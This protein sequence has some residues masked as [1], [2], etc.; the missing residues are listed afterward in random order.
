MFAKWAATGTHSGQKGHGNKTHEHH[1]EGPLR[2]DVHPTGRQVQFS[3]VWE[4]RIAGDVV[5]AIQV[6]TGHF[7]GYELRL[8]ETL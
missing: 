6:Y 4:F 5:I 1:Q 2:P 3:G 7:L 8:R